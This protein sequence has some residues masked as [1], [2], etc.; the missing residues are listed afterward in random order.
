MNSMEEDYHKAKKEAKECKEALESMMLDE[1]QKSI[2][3][4]NVNLKTKIKELQDRGTK[5]TTNAA[6][7]KEM[8]EK[9]D[10][11]VSDSKTLRE[12]KEVLEKEAKDRDHKLN[13]LQLET[14]DLKK[15]ILE[16]QQ[17]CKLDELEIE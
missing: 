3:M 6:K 9:M 13:N 17:R 14:K 4:D 16:Y 12:L 1:D 8:K 15:E 5:K 10:A 7:M 2:E 11:A